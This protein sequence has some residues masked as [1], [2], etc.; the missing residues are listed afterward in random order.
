VLAVLLGYRVIL[1]AI[2]QKN[3]KALPAATSIKTAN[4]EMPGV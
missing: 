3:S 2:S 4:P 1:W